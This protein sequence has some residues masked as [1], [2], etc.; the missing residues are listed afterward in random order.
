MAKVFNFT[1]TN[2][3][4]VIRF[5][6]PNHNHRIQEIVQ[7]LCAGNSNES[8]E[9]K[10]CRY[11]ILEGKGKFAFD[12]IEVEGNDIR[13]EVVFFENTEYPLIVRGKCE[14]LEE[15]TL[16]INDHEKT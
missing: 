15:I 6:C 13:H 9:H 4:I 3:D 1:I 8:D 12:G 16:A 10:I 5:S 14:V 2:E 11:S 7:N